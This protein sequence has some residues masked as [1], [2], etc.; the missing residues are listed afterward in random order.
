M[1]VAEYMARLGYVSMAVD[2]YGD[3]VPG[4][5]TESFRMDPSE[6]E[7]FSETLF[8]QWL[9]L[10]TTTRF[11]ELIGQWIELGPGDERVDK[12][13]PAAIGYCLWNV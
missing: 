7:T 5:P 13:V 10:I 12:T 8:K 11:R 2:R 9:T 4:G 1:D 6:I 3:H